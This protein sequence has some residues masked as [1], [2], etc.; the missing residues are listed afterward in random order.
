MPI[1]FPNSCAAVRSKAA[2]APQLH[3]LSG[4]E[5]PRLGGDKTVPQS[6]LAGCRPSTTMS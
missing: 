2:A 3:P 4:R 1:R 5:K 6:E